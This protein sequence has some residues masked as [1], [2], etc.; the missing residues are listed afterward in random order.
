MDCRIVKIK[1]ACEMLSISRATMYRLIEK[2]EFPKP[3]QLSTRSVGFHIDDINKWIEE[4]R[5]Q[6][7]H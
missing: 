5:G 2:G 4:R 3:M 6:R 7:L 1:G